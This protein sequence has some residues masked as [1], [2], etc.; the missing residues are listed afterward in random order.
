[1]SALTAT[2][3]DAEL[4]GH[5]DLPEA[6]IARLAS[7][8]FVRLPQ[9][10]SP[11][12][13]EHFEPTITEQLIELNTMRLPLDERDTYNRA[14]LQVMNLWRHDDRV[15]RL[16]RSP[17]LAEVAAR[18]LGVDGVRLYHDQALY[19]EPGGGITPWHA[20]QYYWPFASDRTITVWIPLQDTPVELGALEFARGSHRFEFGRDLAISDDSEQELQRE[21]RAQGFPT[22]Q[23]PYALGDASLH[24][25]WTFH[26]AGANTST[27]ARRVMTIIYVDAD[28]IISE[29]TN[30]NQ[31]EDLRVCLPGA[32]VGGVPDTGLNPVLYRRSSAS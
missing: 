31:R 22:D 25:G 26:R 8:G 17:R 20:D 1:M 24:L 15:G 16:V 30:D 10:L 28:I 29:P 18:L 11:A 19:K 14:F 2:A 12:V 13:I 9:L 4:D 6:A 23:A 5:Y 32:T 27:T 3:I 7:D 21:L